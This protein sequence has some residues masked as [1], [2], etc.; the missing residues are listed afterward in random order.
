MKTN[1]I[2]TAVV[3]MLC[4]ALALSAC[5]GEDVTG[6]TQEST[7]T[8]EASTAIETTGATEATDET[9]AEGMQKYTVTIV[10]QDGNPIPGAM[11]QLCKDTC[12]PGVA[13]EQGIATFQVPEADYKVS[14]L[15]LPEGYTYSTEEQEFYFEAGSTEM[16]IALKAEA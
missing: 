16:T 3:L 12:F 9:L 15:S 8:T 5:G 6:T 10:D 11:V 7:T 4:M 13:N 14:F 1:K 2:I